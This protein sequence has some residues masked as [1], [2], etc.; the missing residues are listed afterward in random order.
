MMYVGQ[1]IKGL[2]WIS[3]IQRWTTA[4]A[5]GLGLVTVGWVIALL[6]GLTAVTLAPG[7]VII[8]F[9]DAVQE[10]R[11]DEATEFLSNAAR[12]ELAALSTEEYDALMVELTHDFTSTELNFIGVQNFGKYAVAGVLQ[13]LPPHTVDLRV[14]VLVKEGRHWRIEWPLGVA[15]WFESVERFDPAARFTAPPRD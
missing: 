10:R 2:R 8:A 4:V 3:E 5:I 1:V 15:N 12:E 11:F 7:E 9:Y 6:F 14:E 13:D